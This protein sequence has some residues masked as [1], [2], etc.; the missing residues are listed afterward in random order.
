MARSAGPLHYW[1]WV[2][3]YP[4]TGYSPPVL[5][6][7]AAFITFALG[8]SQTGTGI[9][10]TGLPLLAIS[11]IWA[12]LYMVRVID[13]TVR[14]YGTPPPMTGES[15]HLYTGIKP[16]T[17]PALSASGY[18]A[19]RTAHPL[20]ADALLAFT[21]LVL[22]AQLFDYATSERLLASLNPFRWL[23]VMGEMGLAYVLPS[24]LLFLGVWAV[25]AMSGQ[26]GRF[27]LLLLLFY[28]LVASAHLLGY[29][30]F[31]K[32]QAL[33][34]QVD[35]RH[36]DIVERE[37]TQA[38]QLAAL[39]KRIDARL[40]EQDGAGI[41]RILETEPAAPVSQ[42]QFLE[43]LLWLLRTRRAPL[44]L[45]T[46]ARRLIPLLLAEHQHIRALEVAEAALNANAHF[47]PT[48][49]EHLLALGRTALQQGYENLF[50]RLLHGADARTPQPQWAELHFLYTQYLAE[51]KHDDATALQWLEPLLAYTQHPLHPQFLATA[52]ALRALRMRKAGVQ[53]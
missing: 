40:V 50:Q 18:F 26:L 21:A 38:Q 46:V 2:L 27:G 7:L 31:R 30:G 35:V 53:T 3:R 28:L 24:L 22:P 25:H 39:I 20:A 5:V 11:I 48:S 19:L 33:G 12:V 29:L 52:K 13:H 37:A 45:H 4:L 32:H 34:V 36:P 6:M 51:K 49:P 23:Q 16:L 14:G 8:A 47:A 15:L 43:D 1:P 41:V 44:T 9:P 10:D 17:L 42:R